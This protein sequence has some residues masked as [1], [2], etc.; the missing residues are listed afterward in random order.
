MASF[1]YK[2]KDVSGR[3]VDG[4]MDALDEHAVVAQLQ[5]MG[6][7]VLQVREVGASRARS[8]AGFD[9]VR[10]FVNWFIN[11][12]FGGA[13]VFELAVFYRRL[14]TM[15]TS[16]MTLVQ[17]LNSI[18]MQGGSRRLRKIAGESVEHIQAGG[19]LSDAFARYPWMFPDLH[20]ELIRAGEASGNMDTML[21][22][23]AE[24]LERECAVRQR[25]R[26]AT[27]YPKIL[28]LAV[29]FIPSLAVLFLEG[30]E[31]YMHVTVYKVI[32]VAIFVLV[33]W[34]IYRLLYQIAGFRYALDFIK[35]KI[36]RVG[37]AVRMLA[38]SKVYRIISAMMAAGAPLSRGLRHAADA[39]GNG[40][41]AV[42]LRKAAPMVDRGISLTESLRATGV[43]SPMALDMLSTGEQSGNVDSMLEKAAEYTESD[44]EVLVFQC[45][46]VFGIL[47]LLLVAG[48]I[49]Y[50]V[51]S[52]Y[53]QA[54]SVYS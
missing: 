54:F 1:A 24:F 44:A 27:L 40:Y 10:S 26:F 19:R 52:F 53:M 50:F 29:I 13:T 18:H 45:T 47:L 23:I 8:S 17:S 16:G 7:F 15:V 11:P 14:S 38:L 20:L 35:L 41:L 6:Y 42:R 32:P 33:L 49:A 39:S 2:V 37:S 25:L 28:V 9:P 43:F 31:A 36:P 12:I 3:T 21:S 4:I 22:R 5:R 34:G 30:F 48:Y 46:V 51:V